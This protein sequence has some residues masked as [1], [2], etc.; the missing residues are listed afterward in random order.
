MYKKLGTYFLFVGLAYILLVLGW[1]AFPNSYDPEKEILHEYLQPAKQLKTNSQVASKMKNLSKP[2]SKNP[3][4]S[5]LKS[6]S[7]SR[8]RPIINI[9]PKIIH[10]G[11]PLT[12]SICASGEKY[13]IKFN[14]QIKTSNL[15]KDGCTYASFGIPS[16]AKV[17]SLVLITY[18]NTQGK[19]IKRYLRVKEH[20]DM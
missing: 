1:Q 3:K 9:K 14:D 13:Q 6:K 11:A 5:M 7:I 15:K 18:Q 20:K 17:G 8:S 2:N 12:T 4:N 10:P 19:Q 16:Q